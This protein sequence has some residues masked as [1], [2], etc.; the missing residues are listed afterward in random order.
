MD[1]S[2]TE[3]QYEELFHIQ[4]TVNSFIQ[5]LRELTLR[6]NGHAGFHLTGSSV[7]PISSSGLKKLS[8]IF[9]G[10]QELL[11]C[12]ITQKMDL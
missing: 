11:V 1:L 3:F 4:F 2:D 9:P 8:S 6:R 12:P 10:H 5:Y 7:F